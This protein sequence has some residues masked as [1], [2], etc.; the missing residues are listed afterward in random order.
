MNE[1]NGTLNIP[2]GSADSCRDKFQSSRSSI[3]FP[4]SGNDE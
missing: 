3:S 1:N 2:E 4:Y